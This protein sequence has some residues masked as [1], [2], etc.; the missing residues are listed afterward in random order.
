MKIVHSWLNDLVPVGP[1]TNDADV[2]AIADVITNLGLHVEDI[3][4]VG[5]SVKGVIT[6]KVLRTER[7]P[8]AAKV[9]R[10]YV[11]AGDGVERHVWCGAFNMA[12]GD[13]IP[14]ATPGTV[15]PDGRAIEPKPILGISSD[16]MLCSARELGL[17]DDH[18]GILILPSDV[19]LGVPYGEAL[20]L[21]EEIVYDLDVLRNRPDAWGHLGVARDVAA[22]LGLELAPGAA[23]VPPVEPVRSAAVKL[24][25]GDRCP[26]FTTIV[27]S[28]VVVG[29]SSDW[30][31]RRLSAAGM[32]PLNN[33]VD[34]SNYVMLECNQPNHPYDLDTLGGGG[35]IVRLAKKGEQIVTLD[36]VTRTLTAADLLICDADDVPIGIGGIMGA[37]NSEISDATTTIALEM[38]WFEPNAIM[39]SAARLGLR[40]EASARFERGVDPFGV[41]RA[42]A[43]FVE[44]LKLTCPNLVVHAGA[45]DEQ[46]KSLPGSNVITVRPAAVSALLGTNFGADAISALIVPI[47]FTCEPAGEALSVTAPTWRPDCTM[48]VDIIEEV[49]R[50]H[51][52][53]LLGKTVPKSTEPGGLT[54]LQHRRRRLREVLLGLGISEA[55]PH[56]FLA[57]DDL[58]RAGLPADALRLTNPLA[59]GDDVLRT[60]LR[61]G[62]LKALALNKSHRQVGVSLFEIGHVYPPSDDV[63]PAEYEALA[64]VLAGSE[65]AD[66]VAVWRELASA[67]GWGARLDQSNVPDGMHPARSATLSLG[68][69]PVGVVGEVHPDVADAFE[70]NERVA[71]LELNLTVLL[72]ND[73]SVARWKP[74][75][76][77]PSSDLD[78]AF[79]VPNTVTAEKVDKA[80]RQAAG[81]L[82]VDV[83]LFDVYRGAA[84]G[85]GARSLAYRLR[86]QAP[87][88][89]LTDDDVAA[90]RTKVEAATIKLGASLRG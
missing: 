42:C 31:R 41:A 43:R 87:D 12:A 27:L 66:A 20:G 39:A 19:Q 22:K 36:D 68:R 85:E 79:V 88:R 28:G 13:I 40:S 60:S 35:F 76:R 57:A 81:A 75:S 26:R 24:V 51:G 80:I 16:G 69:D 33:V 1:S 25:A 14:L 34:V 8:D 46:S 21:G 73:P 6:A 89:T 47:G 32:R 71:L 53:D 90:V 55:M 67:M 61:P 4:R 70:V 77:F 18:A 23:V 59:A 54:A 7:H 65:A 11:D 29:P 9:H 15:M 5:S 3:A 10:V 62:L 52:Y 38:A 63:L 82:V 45:V 30:M 86:L 84:A 58:S 2:D 78:L 49:A 72:A 48:E 74:T 37:K 17:G 50:H 83:Q 44:L 56:P 64:V